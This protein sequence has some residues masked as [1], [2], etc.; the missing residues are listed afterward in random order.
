M[1][2]ATA[3]ETNERNKSV[4]WQ[5]WADLD[6]ASP[7]EAASALRNAMAPDVRWR[8]FAPIGPLVGVEAVVEQFWLPLSA[9][10]TDLRRETHIF[11]GGQS[12]GRADG[13]IAKDGRW[14]VSGTGLFSGV[15]DQDFLTIPAN[16]QAVSIRWGEF[17]CFEDGM[18]TEVY[19]LVDLVDLMQQAGFEVLP[20]ARGADRIYPAPAAGD[21]VLLKSDD[22]AESAHSLEHIRA[23]IYDGLNAFDESDLASMGMADWFHPE[24]KWYGPG[25]IGACLSFQEFES[26]HQ[27]PWLVAFPDR[28]VQDLDAI[29]AEGAYSG[30]PGWSGVL[31]THTGPYLDVA[32]TQNRIEFNG[33]DWWKRVD[34]VYI[35]N[36][37]FV[38]MVHL[39]EQFG[40][41]LLARAR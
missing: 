32:A 38:D 11:M 7:S 23:F 3:N 35:E 9:S 13:D 36:W 19:F 30:A 37:V 27:A 12:N 1:T 15:F 29:I 8:G 17:C 18:I 41:D 6:S 25:G 39:F 2:P 10:F 33:L 22:S 24:L 16:G 20:P 34:E 5:L 4:T 21:G 31:A 28:Q 26:L 40:I 14:W